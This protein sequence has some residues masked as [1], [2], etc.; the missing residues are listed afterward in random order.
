MR[1]SRRKQIGIIIGLSVMVLGCLLAETGK[2]KIQKEKKSQVSEEKAAQ[3]KTGAV[4]REKITDNMNVRVLLMTTG[5]ASIFH[6]KVKIT[7]SKPFTVTVNGKKKEYPA[8]GMASFQ[9]DKKYKGKKIMIKP[10]KGAKLKVLSVER[11]GIHPSY[12]HTLKVA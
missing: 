10:S 5:F 2:R 9:N 12:R 8:E 7:S 1:K 3:K 6:E 4:K 11:K